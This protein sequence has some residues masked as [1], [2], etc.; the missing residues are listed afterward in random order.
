MLYLIIKKNK[1]VN[2]MVQF[3]EPE[4][5]TVISSAILNQNTFKLIEKIIRWT[6]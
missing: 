6:N 4:I 3:N 5:K 2:L 1:M